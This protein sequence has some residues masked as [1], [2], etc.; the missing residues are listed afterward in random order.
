MQIR[1]GWCSYCSSFWKFDIQCFREAHLLYYSTSVYNYVGTFVQ[2]TNWSLSQVTESSGK[3]FISHGLIRQWRFLHS[4]R[5]D[6]IYPPSAPLLTHSS[7]FGPRFLNSG[8]S[9][10]SELDPWHFPHIPPSPRL[11]V[12]RICPIFRNTFHVQILTSLT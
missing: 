4:H 7:A 8:R 9:K 11:N 6:E 3:Q 2:V 12:C 5:N 1:C 10:P